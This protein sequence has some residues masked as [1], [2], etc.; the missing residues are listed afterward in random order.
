MFIWPLLINSILIGY[1]DQIIKYSI[2]VP[3]SDDFYLWTIVHISTNTL[4]NQHCFQVNDV[5]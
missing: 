1:S 3:G 4:S 5:N 2:F